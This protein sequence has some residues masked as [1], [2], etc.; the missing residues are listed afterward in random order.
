MLTRVTLRTSPT[1]LHPF[2]LMS[3]RHRHPKVDPLYTLEVAIWSDFESGKLSLDEIHRQ[4]ESY[5]KKLRVDGYE[6]Y[7]HHDD[8]KR[9][10]TVTVG[11]F[12]R[13]AL[14]A[15]TGLYG[16]AVEGVLQRFPARLVN[17]ETLREP[18]DGRNP[19][20]GTRVQQPRLVH[21]PKL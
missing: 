17:G 3:A 14:D 20:R 7:F 11:L 5:A 2:A 9:L 8:D 18:I 15:R 1:R 10:S 13:T 19:T 6:A 12:D 21:V 16:H 4:A